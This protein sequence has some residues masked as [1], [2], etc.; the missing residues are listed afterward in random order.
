MGKAADSVSEVEYRLAELLMWDWLSH[1]GYRAKRRFFALCAILVPALLILFVI[2]SVVRASPELRVLLLVVHWIIGVPLLVISLLLFLQSERVRHSIEALRVPEDALADLEEISAQNPDTPIFG[3]HYACFFR[4][5]TLV[6]YA[7]IEQLESSVSKR[8]ARAGDITAFRLY[9]KQK[10]GKYVPLHSIQERVSGHAE[11][12]QRIQ[13]T[14]RALQERIP[15][16]QVVQ[17]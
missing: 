12:R 5:G 17:I 16:L 1:G 13:E 9:A 3:D 2:L 6:E 4:S 7:Q 11:A 15:G 8:I 14:V 10:D